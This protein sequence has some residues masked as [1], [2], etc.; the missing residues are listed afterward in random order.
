MGSDMLNVLRDFISTLYTILCV[1]VYSL[2]NVYS[3]SVSTVNS[4]WIK[5]DSQSL[6]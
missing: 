3:E 1:C 2:Y 4:S 6:L 5:S